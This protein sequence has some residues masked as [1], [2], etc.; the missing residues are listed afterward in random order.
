M[1]FTFNNKTV[2]ST[3]QLC[4][5][6]LQA[7]LIF[8]VIVA[9]KNAKFAEEAIRKL[10]PMDEMPFDVIKRYGADLRKKLELARTGNY[11]KLCNC[12]PGLVQLNPRT[13]TLAE[14][15]AINGIGPKTSRFFV[16]WTGRDI[17]CAA[18]D[19]HIL[20][21]LRELG[22]SAPKSTP[23]AGPEYSRL[24]QLFLRE[25]KKRKLSPNRLDW[26]VWEAY[27]SKDEK[28]VAKLK[29]P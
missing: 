7:R 23:P 9:G 25:A 19:V 28:A 15:E 3:D 6:E 16:L 26:L 22:Y 12:L 1:S 2:D 18:L 4:D 14:L 11:T 8:S 24:E 20:R 10:L 27:S 29:T 5:W 13:C 21:F 17:P